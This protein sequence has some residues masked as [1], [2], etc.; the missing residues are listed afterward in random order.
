MQLVTLRSEQKPRPALGLYGRLVKA[1]LQLFL[2]TVVRAKKLLSV[3]L[4]SFELIKQTSLF[5]LEFFRRYPTGLRAEGLTVATRLLDARRPIVL[6]S[7]AIID[8]EQRL[9]FLWTPDSQRTLSSICET[10]LH[11]AVTKESRSSLKRIA[12]RLGKYLDIPTG[13]YS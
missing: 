10:A 5:V 3:P 12:D 4:C 6:V 2:Q 13:H 7:P 1:I 9:Q 11:A 8:M